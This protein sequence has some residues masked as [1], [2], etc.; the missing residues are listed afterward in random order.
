[1]KNIKASSPG[2]LIC[3][4]ALGIM[5][6]ACA[7]KP[8]SADSNAAIDSAARV[9]AQADANRFVLV[10]FNKGQA[11][12]SEENKSALRALAAETPQRAVDEVKVLAWS[13]REYPASGSKATTADV[14]LAT[15][16]GDNI[17]KYLKS[18]LGYKVDVDNHNMAKRPAAISEILGTDDYEIKNKMEVTG[19]MP[20]TRSANAPSVLGD[21]ASTALV[22]VKFER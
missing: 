15:N 19:E 20:A 10:K 9:A 21:K 13:D 3:A 6:I 11:G 16:R 8:K 5:V 1:M 12:L 18:D 22:M 2:F 14:K 4:L 7:E 17:T